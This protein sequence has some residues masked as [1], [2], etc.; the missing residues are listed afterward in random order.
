MINISQLNKEFESRVRLGIMSVLM[1]NDWVDFS[2]MKSLLEITDG[3]LASH[4]NALEKS[5]Y[6][7]VKKEFVGKKPKTSYRVTQNGRTA[8][9]E[10][11]NALEKLIGK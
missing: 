7:E 5:N 2:E 11:L 3:N 10:H 8:F 9:T 4:S 6:I 1:V